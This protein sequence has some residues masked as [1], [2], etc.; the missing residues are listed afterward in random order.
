M[1]DDLAKF[2]PA[3]AG[4]HDPGQIVIL[5]DNRMETTKD[6]KKSMFQSYWIEGMYRLG[7]PSWQIPDLEP[8]KLRLI[9]YTHAG[10]EGTRD[11]PLYRAYTVKEMFDSLSDEGF[12]PMILGY[13]GENPFP[14]IGGSE[15]P[16][17][18]KKPK[19]KVA[20]SA[21]GYWSGHSGREVN[22]PHERVM[23][24]IEKE[25]ER[26]AEKRAEE[27]RRAEKAEGVIVGGGAV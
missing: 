17:E 8:G 18:P 9:W 7:W 5:F 21:S 10:A 4:K 15:P 23:K 20:T 2:N 26:E 16:L 27:V 11:Y 3:T 25:E 14:M 1:S 13:S 12:R 24:I 19:V 6:D 22:T